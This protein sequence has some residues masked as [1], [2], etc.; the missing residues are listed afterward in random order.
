MSGLFSPLDP[1][2]SHLRGGAVCLGNFDGVHRGHRA[3]LARVRDL[4]ERVGGPSIAVTFDPP[5]GQLLRPHIHRP[6]L[7]WMARRASLIR[8]QGID[9]VVV[10]HTTHD[11]L[12]WSAERFI[13]E[14]LIERLAIRGIAEGPDFRFGHQRG[15]DLE[16]LRERGATAGFAVEVVE[17][18]QDEGEWISSSR[19]RAALLDGE[20]DRANRWLA[21]PY[22]MRGRVETGAQRGR[23]LGFPTANLGGRDNLAPAIGVYAG[24]AFVG[25]R[26]LAAAIHIGPNPTFE[27]DGQLKV[28]AHLLDFEGDLYDQPLELELLERIRGVMRFPNREA[29]MDQIHRDLA[30]V[31]REFDRASQQNSAPTADIDMA[32]DG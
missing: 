25:T 22:R 30:A 11:L 19:V 8:Q 9:A 29:L 13:Q 31:R 27:A 16:L 15:G 21:S 23:Q 6:P 12:G 28:E 20:L 18:T 7:T 26:R 5:P 4:A 24:T 32:S 17:P 3:L 14:I 1:L 10:C 2:P